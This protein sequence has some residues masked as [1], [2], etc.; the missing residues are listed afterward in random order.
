MV[1]KLKKKKFTAGKKF[2][3][4]GDQKLEFTNP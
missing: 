1:K 4:L 3:F 2:N